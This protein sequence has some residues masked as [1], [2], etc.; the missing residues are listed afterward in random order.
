MRGT[1][2]VDPGST[3]HLTTDLLAP[4]RHRQTAPASRGGKSF[5]QAMYTSQGASVR[6]YAPKVVGSRDQQWVSVPSM[7]RSGQKKTPA[8]QCPSNVQHSMPY[9]VKKQFV[10]YDKGSLNIQKAERE[11]VQDEVLTGF[12]QSRDNFRVTRI[13]KGEAINNPNPLSVIP[14][15]NICNSF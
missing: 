14:K 9:L 5:G 7:L 1:K 6:S 4:S 12:Y 11:N 15:I 2:S 13:G 3:Y 10:C 8:R